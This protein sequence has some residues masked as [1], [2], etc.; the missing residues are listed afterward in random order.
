MLATVVTLAMSPG[1]ALGQGTAAE[2]VFRGG[3]RSA[4]D[5]AESDE[6][7]ASGKVGEPDR[8][9]TSGVTDTLDE[10]GEA[11]ES[12]ESGAPAKISGRLQHPEARR[13]Y[14]AAN[15]YFVEGRYGLAAQQLGFAY[16]VEPLPE[17]LPQRALVLDAAGR[18]VEGIPLLEDYLVTSPSPARARRAQLMID[19]CRKRNGLP[20][21]SPGPSAARQGSAVDG[22]PRAD[23]PE[24]NAGGTSASTEPWYRDPAGVVLLGFGA[25]G[26]SAGVGLMIAVGPPRRRAATSELH[27]DYADNTRRATVLASFG[28]GAFV[29]GA[30]LMVGALLRFRSRRL[31]AQGRPQASAWIERGGAGL[32]L[33][34]RF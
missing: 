14:D 12:G 10:A 23:R 17:L 11:G 16:A 15:R 33:M 13:Y 27:S 28:S 3:G 18:C 29:A 9:D 21:I 2:L 30:A 26:L 19:D 31:E 34:G 20:P 25:L 24:A 8:S 1:V 6:P 22:R 32:G 7:D 4:E 5:R